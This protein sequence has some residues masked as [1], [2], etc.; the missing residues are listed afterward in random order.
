MLST[1]TVFF[2]VFISIFIVG[3]NLKNSEAIIETKLS[4]G[5]TMGTCIFIVLPYAVFYLN[6]LGTNKFI[7]HAFA[8]IIFVI[9]LFIAKAILSINPVEF[10]FFISIIL[11]LLFL[12]PSL[13]YG[14]NFK[15]YLVE[16]ANYFDSPVI[17]N[18][19]FD[20]KLTKKIR[21]LNNHYTISTPE[22]WKLIQKKE[23][24]KTTYKINNENNEIN[25]FY[26][27]CNQ[28]DQK[29]ISDIVKNLQ[30]SYTEEN[31]T[32][33]RQCFKWKRNNYA[34]KLIHT[35]KA[36]TIKKITWLATDNKTHRR[37][38]LEFKT[39]TK[40]NNNLKIIDAIFNSIKYTNEKEHTGNCKSLI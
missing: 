4:F 33:K 32:I 7:T 38:I 2:L 1:F 29:N 17:F 27:Y 11:S 35:N 14:Y 39:N 15:N 19:T 26:M 9:F 25:Q 3:R 28:D 10:S 12:I 30:D 37:L 36:R 5:I 40:N 13:I 24:S 31:K 16:K 18:G 20:G 23:T 6:L 34:C 22:N 8:A 21:S